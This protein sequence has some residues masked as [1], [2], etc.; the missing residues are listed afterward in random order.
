MKQTFIALVSALLLCA[1][2]TEAQDRKLMVHAVCF[3]NLENLFDTC[4][5]AHKNDYDFL[6]DG[7]YD[8]KIGILCDI[9]YGTTLFIDDIR[10]VEYATDSNINGVFSSPSYVTGQFS[11]SGLP[12]CSSHKGLSIIRQS[13]GKVQKVIGK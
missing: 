12:L 5:D 1:G 9:D 11:L 8:F 4:H 13:N 2:L 7:S 3:Y 10:I 6:P